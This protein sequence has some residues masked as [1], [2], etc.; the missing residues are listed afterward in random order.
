MSVTTR[1]PRLYRAPGDAEHDSMRAADNHDID[2]LGVR[3][4][5]HVIATRHD[6]SAQTN[7]VG[8]CTVPATYVFCIDSGIAEAPRR[9][10]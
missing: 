3:R 7:V 4:F 5:V 9:A 6:P 2:E 10:F 1:F 8:A